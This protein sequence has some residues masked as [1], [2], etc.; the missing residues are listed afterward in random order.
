M[1]IYILRRLVGV[2]LYDNNKLCRVKILL[3]SFYD[4]IKGKM[5]KT[6]K[7]KYQ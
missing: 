1:F 2:L 7:I 6:L 3:R 5:G 4:G